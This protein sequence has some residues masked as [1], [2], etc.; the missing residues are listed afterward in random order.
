MSSTASSIVQTIF[1][2]LVEE[3]L[4][5]AGVK[6]TK[7]LGRERLLAQRF[8]AESQE[9]A[10]NELASAMSGRW[11][12]SNRRAALTMVVR[13]F[14]V[15]DLPVDVIERAGARRLDAVRGEVRM[16][17]VSFRY[18]GDRLDGDWTLRDV[19]FVVP[20]GTTT[21]IVGE[22]GAG[23]TTLAYLVARLYEV[24]DGAVFVD[25]YDV[26]ELTLD[27]V[28]DAVGLAAQ[29]TYLFHDTL[30]ANLRFAAPD[31]TDPEL[32]AAV[33]AA[34]IDRVVASLPQGYD[35]G[36]GARGYR[37]S[38]GERQRLTIARML[39]RNPRILILE[40]ATSALDTETGR[41]V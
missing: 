11:L 38:G 14:E 10:R 35:T 34:R 24:D 3:S 23:K 4:S 5:V 17:G 29:D 21:A 1:A 22:P 6:L 28:S 2:G 39:L 37:F 25:G 12:L 15:L 9:R 8:T 41:A 7:T 26:R 19:D 32:D 30:A 40:E 16:T 36:V 31:A 18:D 20:A 33:R 27:S 13:I